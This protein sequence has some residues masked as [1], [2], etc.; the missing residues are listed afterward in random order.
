MRM[1]RKTALL[2]T[3]TV[4]EATIRS[5]PKTAAVVA[6]AHATWLSPPTSDWAARPASSGPVHPKP[7]S[8]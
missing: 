7:A 2:A 6:K 3:V 8:R 4:T 1:G 5:A